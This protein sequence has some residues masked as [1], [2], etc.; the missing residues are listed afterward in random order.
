MERPR[1]ERRD[2]RGKQRIKEGKTL[3][4][5]LSIL[6]KIDLVDWKRKISNQRTTV[7]TTVSV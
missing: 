1:R 5:F 4:L 2:G 6:K 3:V 7:E